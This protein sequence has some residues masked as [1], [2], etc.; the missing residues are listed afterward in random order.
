MKHHQSILA[1][2]AA[3]LAFGPVI[4]FSQQD[5]DQNRLA[6]PSNEDPVLVIEQRGD[7]EIRAGSAYGYTLHVRNVSDKSL[8]NVRIHQVLPSSF[9]LESESVKSERREQSATAGQGRQL[10]GERAAAN[11]QR[12]TESTTREWQTRSQQTAD[13]DAEEGDAWVREPR[14]DRPRQDRDSAQPNRSRG[15]PA[16]EPADETSAS[17]PGAQ[18]RREQRE[19]SD[20]MRPQTR[21]ERQSRQTG[22]VARRDR[23]TTD[24]ARQARQERQARQSR[25]DQRQ[26]SRQQQQ[27]Q[28][29]R[30]TMTNRVWTIGM[31]G[32]D[33]ERQIRISGVPTQEGE[34]ESC[35]FATFERAL[36]TTLTVTRPEL[37]LTREWINEDGK[38]AG[39]FLICD[40]VRVRYTLRNEGSGTTPEATI[41]EDLPEGLTTRDGKRRININAGE[42]AAGE[43]ETFTVA[44]KAQTTGEVSSR[45]TAKAGDL[46]SRSNADPIRLDQA[47]IDVSV[48]G[49]GTQ[50][51]GR[52]V[53]YQ[54]TVTN[55]SDEVPAENT[56]VRIPGIDQRMRFANSDRE[57]P[58]D[59]DV[60]T[61]GTLPP[62]ESRSFGISFS[63]EE[64]GEISTRVEAM[65][66]C[67]ETATTHISTEFQGVAALQ[68]IVT[69][70]QDPVPQGEQT[71]YEIVVTNEG[72]AR[73]AGISLTGKLPAH[74]EFVS[75]T[76]DSSVNGEGRELSFDPVENL[77]PGENASWLVTVRGVKAGK[78][79]FRVNVE[80]NSGSTTIG[81]PTTVY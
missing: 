47:E 53:E 49:R 29:D 76:G 5:R 52:D 61:L 18:T 35:V 51:L 68:A 70:H 16:D 4:A 30:E 75:A 42:I 36:C 23:S 14:A 34:L 11:R 64:A 12:P 7:K 28:T 9:Q 33:E 74:L 48:K 56:R 21:Q 79:E 69:D 32:P 13:R 50:Y 37:R 81:E 6:Y 25:Q 63:A 59:V 67:A 22:E 31:L 2:G 80:S 58:T 73:D 1:A 66:R 43:Q 54:I 46:T 17:R 27:P 57:I 8:H 60:F 38:K 72:T 78:G 62:G 3:A 10:R 55:L 71:V 26:A 24:E 44:L 40:P 77:Q 39:R 41:T 65:A 19:S 45:A 20:E 15:E